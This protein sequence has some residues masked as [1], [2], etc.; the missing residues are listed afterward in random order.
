MKNPSSSVL[1]NAQWNSLAWLRGKISAVF[2]VLALFVTAPACSPFVDP[3]QS[4]DE[5][6]EEDLALRMIGLAVSQ[7]MEAA[8]TEYG[9]S[10]EDAAA[11]AAA[12]QAEGDLSLDDLRASRWGGAG[13][14]LAASVERSDEDR[15]KDYLKAVSKGAADEIGARKSSLASA[16]GGAGAPGVL[17]K[18][19]EIMIQLLADDTVREAADLD[20]SEIVLIV[21]AIQSGLIENG[22]SSGVASASTP[23]EIQDLAGRLLA[24]SW[25]ALDEAGITSAQI[26]QAI[27][28]ILVGGFESLLAAQVSESHGQGAVLSLMVKLGDLLK[29]ADALSINPSGEAVARAFS[30]GMLAR[31]SAADLSA[32]EV[33]LCDWLQ[34]LLVQL[35]NTPDDISGLSVI[36]QESATAA[37]HTLS[38]S[39]SDS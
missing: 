3:G 29:S 11:I 30:Q 12:A 10:P 4:G 18:I 32:T 38:S 34:E 2:A 13:E 28:D 23:S 17:A 25:A 31:A 7:D 26:D 16:G 37:G 1:S 22:I 15:V 9:I 33:V 24:S 6:S 8:L 36:I 14:A 21:N 27:A 20:E 19:A 5:I 35:D 39:C